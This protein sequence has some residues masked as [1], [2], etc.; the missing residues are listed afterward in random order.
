MCFVNLADKKYLKQREPIYILK[1]L[2]CR[3]Y[4][5][6]KLTQFSPGN[7]VLDAADSNID[8]FL[9]LYAWV[10]STQLNIH[11]LSKKSLSSP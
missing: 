11:I 3:K 2:S 9:W 5:L 7:N 8:G 1:H 10:S 4:S 6:Q